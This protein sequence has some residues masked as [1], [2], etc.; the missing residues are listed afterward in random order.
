MRVELDPARREAIALTLDHVVAERVDPPPPDLRLPNIRW[1]RLRSERLSAFHD[2]T[3]EHR[4][5][6]ALP[7]GFDDPRL[8]DYRWPVI[9]EIPGYGGRD[10]GAIDWA[11]TLLIPRVDEIAPYA[12]YVVLDPESPLGHHGFC[13]SANNG[14]VGTALVEE[15]IPFLTSEFR[16]TDRN[17]GRLVMGHSSGGW[18][19]LWLQ[20]EHPE[21]F[22]GCWSSAP[23]PVDFSAFETSDLYA[24]ANLYFGPDGSLR[25][26]FRELATVEGLM[27]MTMSAREENAMEHA[28]DPHG[29][30]G[31]QWDAWEAM[32]SPRDPATGLP[33]PMFDPLS[34]RIDR[35]VVEHWARF[36]IARRLS[37]DWDRRWPI[38]R[39]RVR[40]NVGGIDSFYLERA[41]AAL[42]QK[43]ERRLAGDAWS[44]AGYVRIIPDETHSTVA[45][46][47]ADRVNHEMRAHLIGAGFRSGPPTE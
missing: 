35:S 42:S 33:T 29:R 20:L 37:D 8:A 41:V 24:D 6:I 12:V 44:G 3:V 16:L 11:H 18:S 27:R 25:G 19:S 23:D 1:V 15:L 13:D 17:E 38:M 14:P 10:D 47:I 28:I 9:F 32:F 36:D 21:S 40:L 26:S 45:R 22:G 31:Q 39:D 46:K 5:G 7:A 4:A 2:R 34:G 30:S 43:M